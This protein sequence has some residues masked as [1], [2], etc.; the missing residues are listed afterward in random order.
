M[1]EDVTFSL[2]IK[3]SIK[4]LKQIVLAHRRILML[5]VVCLL[6]G[7]VIDV[8]LVVVIKMML[9]GVS[10]HLWYSSGHNPIYLALMIMLIIC[11]RELIAVLQNNRL[12]LLTFN[13][14][15]N[16]KRK[17]VITHRSLNFTDL[18]SI[19]KN[20]ILVLFRNVDDIVEFIRQGLVVTIREAMTFIGT[21]IAMLYLNTTLAL[22]F[23]LVLPFA[24][25]MIKA[26]G[27]KSKNSAEQALVARNTL[28]QHL[29]HGHEH[30]IAFH[31][32]RLA[33]DD[34]LSKL[35]TLLASYKHNGMSLT[36]ASVWLSMITQ[37][38]I[39]LM[40]A[41]IIYLMLSGSMGATTGTM[42]A[43]LYAVGR[44]RAPA[45]RIADLR[46]LYDQALT[47]SEDISAFLD[48]KVGNRH[49]HQAN[50]IEWQKISMLDVSYSARNKLVLNKIN[51]TFNKGETI[52]LSGESGVG[53]TTLL[54]I[55]ALLLQPTFGLIKI[56]DFN[57]TEDM[58]DSWFESMVY[59]E[60]FSSLLT[61]SMRENLTAF[62]KANDEMCTE[63]LKKAGLE[64]W[65]EKNSLDTIVGDGGVPLSGGER[66]RVVLAR[67]MLQCAGKSVVL[68]DEVFA[69]LDASGGYNLTKKL[70]EYLKG[71]LVI[72]V[73]HSVN[74]YDLF[75][76]ILV[77]DRERGLLETAH[78]KFAEQV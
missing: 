29:I 39:G 27:V 11:I 44:L 65:L 30:W 74:T 25:S 33:R 45:K 59:V 55:F 35:S 46:S 48:R 22:S 50:P 6:L 71:S 31:T 4:L 42:A 37:F 70:L 28:N 63:I 2:R 61:A 16:L 14:G 54:H 66:Q 67:I 52:L 53:K 1:Q 73:S 56:D 20:D 49:Y 38:W 15:S 32:N 26:M 78:D 76:R 72:A 57:L 10:S 18:I 75:E 13:I 58:Q 36:M 68:L 51:C 40:L 77:L 23:M 60:Q 62:S 43:F 12:S 47:S 24:T 3:S 21:V 7:T 41:S 9:D 17:L 34:Y 8:G 19:S 5:A 64:S 69:A